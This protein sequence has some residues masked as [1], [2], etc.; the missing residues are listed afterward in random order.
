MAKQRYLDLLSQALSNSVPQAQ[1]DATVN[2]LWDS[3]VKRGGAIHIY[4]NNAAELNQWLE[5]QNYAGK[6]WRPEIKQAVKSLIRPLDAPAPMPEAMPHESLNTAIQPA[7]MAKTDDDGFKKVIIP[8]NQKLMREGVVADPAFIQ[9]I[10]GILGRVVALEARNQQLEE[11]IE[12]LNNGFNNLLRKTLA[13]EVHLGIGVNTGVEEIVTEAMTEEA[14]EEIEEIEEIEEGTCYESTRNTDASGTPILTKESE[15][16][17][18]IDNADSAKWVAEAYNITNRKRR[19]YT[20]REIHRLFGG[21]GKGKEA[22][23]TRY[24]FREIKKLRKK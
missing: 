4:D 12:V 3:I 23:L 22:S 11:E 15:Q 24:I 5:E 9:D 21:D 6:H 2:E 18:L 16:Q 20:T 1:L 17:Y 19:G 10:K 14:E 13:L 7:G 8:A